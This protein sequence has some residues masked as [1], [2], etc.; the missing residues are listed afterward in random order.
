MRENN[1]SAGDVLQAFRFLQPSIMQALRKGRFKRPCLSIVVADR[2]T[3]SP[4]RPDD[5]NPIFYRFV[6]PRGAISQDDPIMKELS[7]NARA[8]ARMSWRT[9]YSSR[10]LIYEKPHLLL[11]GDSRFPGSAV[12]DNV[13]TGVSGADAWDD[14]MVSAQINSAIVAIRH[15]RTNKFLSESDEKFF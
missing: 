4:D 7:A 14:E 11:P 9:G 5:F 15:G 6:R 1:L 13:V 2:L 12:L 8:K 3:F 10:T